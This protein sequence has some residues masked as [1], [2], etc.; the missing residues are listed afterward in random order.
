[1]KGATITGTNESIKIRVIPMIESCSIIL[2]RGL[3]AAMALVTLARLPS[4]A[5]EVGTKY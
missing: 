1:M 2:D 4:T 3:A 5:S